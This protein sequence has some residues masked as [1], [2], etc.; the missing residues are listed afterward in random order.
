MVRF[1]IAAL[2]VVLLL[3]SQAAAQ[4]LA[5]QMTCEQAINYYEKNGVI[6]VIANGRFA[7][8]LRPGT[9]I[10]QAATLQCAD[11]GRSP[12]AYTIST[13]DT[14]RCAIAVTC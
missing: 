7:V 8:P 1:A 11:Q 2:F 6:Y 4:A 12:R 14:W 5:D 13:R 3:P 10:R 9:P